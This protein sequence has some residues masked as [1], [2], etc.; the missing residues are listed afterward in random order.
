MCDAVRMRLLKLMALAERGIG[1]ERENAKAALEAALA[2]HGLK[3]EDL[4]DGVQKRADFAY[5]GDFERR[6]L[7]QVLATVCGHGVTIYRSRLARGML[8]VMVTDEQC[9]EIE[10]LWTRHRKNL[11][12]ELDLFFSAYV[13]RQKLFPKDGPQHEAEIMTAEEQ[14]RLY[15]MMA[16]MQGI[17]RVIVRKQIG[18]V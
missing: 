8:A 17:E 5:R 11:K 9:V 7:V 4:F 10:M 16:M 13:H 18:G 15:R 14:E 12:S 6:L 3:L 2:K 1:G